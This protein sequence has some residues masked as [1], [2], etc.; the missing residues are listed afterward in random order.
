MVEYLILSL[1][2]SDHQTEYM[3]GHHENQ[4][5]WLAGYLCHR[6]E[7]AILGPTGCHPVWARCH[8]EG[9]TPLVDADVGWSTRAKSFR[10]L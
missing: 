3:G 8:L 6:I 4:K 9:G 2:D 7:V 1:R 5:E 10:Q